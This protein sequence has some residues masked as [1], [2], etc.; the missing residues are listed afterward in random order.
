MAVVRVLSP[1]EH[2]FLTD[3]RPGYPMAFY[4]HCNVEGPL[5][6]GRLERALGEAA[7]RHPLTRSRVTKS[8]WFPSWLPPDREPQLVVYRLGDGASAAACPD[9]WAPIDLRRAS[10]VRMVA[11]ERA[12]DSWQVVLHVQHPV[13]DGLAGIEF[14]GDVWSYYGGLP[15]APFKVPARVARRRT[16]ERPEDLLHAGA[17]RTDTDPVGAPPVEPA[18]SGWLP[19]LADE[20]ARFARFLPAKLARGPAARGGHTAEHHEPGPALPYRTMTFDRAETT[21]IK[22]RAVAAGVMLNDIVVA[23]VM[24]ACIAWNDVAGHPSASVRITMPASLKP[25]G[26]RAPVGN[27]MGYAFLDRSAGECRSPARLVA[28]LG[29]ASRWIQEHRAAEAFLHTL[30]AVRRFPPLLWGLTRCP[31]TLSTAVV[32]SVGNTGPR[33]KANVPHDGGLALPG[34]L[35]ISGFAGVPPVRPGTRLAVGVVM[36]GG[37]LTLATLCDE[38]ALGVAAPALLADLIRREVRTCTAALPPPRPA[39]DAAS[40]AIPAESD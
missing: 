6:A 14:L 27:D 7:T 17:P 29:A 30:E 24:R 40:T 12:P 2:L 9:P 18:G 3:Q 13:C 37:R 21:A 31:A 32:S 34:G 33:M 11:I 28:S 4:L 5:D 10:G 15:P 25:A 20:T 19:S 35:R 26:T 1:L 22:A 8:A 38:N 39:S 16:A 23:A 36:Y